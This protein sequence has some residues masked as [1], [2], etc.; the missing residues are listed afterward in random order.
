MSS[1]RQHADF[2]SWGDPAVTEPQPLSENTADVIVVGAG[3]AGSTTAYY[4]AK[5]GLDVLLL[6]KT[7]FPRE[8]VC[9]DGLTPRA[10]KQL[11]SMGIDISEEAGW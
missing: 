7:A 6:E 4:L 1:A 10:T 5:A 3:P 8:K 9:G 11:V 2:E